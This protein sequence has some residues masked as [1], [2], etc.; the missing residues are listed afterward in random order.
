[1]KKKTLVILSICVFVIS[2][3]MGGGIIKLNNDY[4][5][6]DYL[7]RICGGDTE[8]MKCVYTH[9]EYNP[10]TY[11]HTFYYQVTHET[12]ISNDYKTVNILKDGQ[13]NDIDGIL[14]IAY[15]NNANCWIELGEDVLL[16]KNTD[17][18]KKLKKGD[19]ITKE[20]LLAIASDLDNY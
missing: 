11:K 15:N 12:D 20:E 5:V 6:D 18:F 3:A 2:L 9:V 1:M 10:F 19:K 7:V 14:D 8:D 16:V 4:D 17:D 13:K